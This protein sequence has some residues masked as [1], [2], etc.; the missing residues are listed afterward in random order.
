MDESLV[1]INFVDMGSLDRLTSDG[2]Q[3]EFFPRYLVLRTTPGIDHNGAASPDDGA[4]RG[5]FNKDQA[6]RY[7]NGTCSACGPYGD[8]PTSD[9][10]LMP[11]CSA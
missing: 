7:K 6:S 3:V 8:S 10:S 9:V 11:T 4:G 5:L 1:H 2:C